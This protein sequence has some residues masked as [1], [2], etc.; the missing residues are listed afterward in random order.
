[1]NRNDE[2]IF[3]YSY[4]AC[5][6]AI[7][8]G[9]LSALLKSNIKYFP[10]KNLIRVFG[11]SLIGFVYFIL[12]IHG[13]EAIGFSLVS[14][15]TGLIIISSYS[16]T[17]KSN[18]VSKLL[19]FLGKISYELYLFHIIILGL[20]RGIIVPKNLS[21]L[22]AIGLLSMFLFCS[23]LISYLISRFYSEPI[24]RFFRRCLMA[25]YNC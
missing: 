17:F 12:G 20:I 18:V 14:L 23:V 6:D 9:I 13:F 2:I 3:M 19:S 21:G 22:P 16:Q 4:L 24:N 15:G 10:Q 7:S 11:F 5:S 25:K 1:M 8:I